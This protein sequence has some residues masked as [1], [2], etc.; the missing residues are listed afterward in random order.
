MRRVYHIGVGVDRQIRL[1]TLRL[2]TWLFEILGIWH[3]RH[4][5]RDV[6]LASLQENAIAELWR[7]TGLRFQR[8][9]RWF[10][11][12]WASSGHFDERTLPEILYS[13]QVE[14]AL[15]D[16]FKARHLA[17]KA[18]TELILAGRS[19]VAVPATRL[20]RSN[21][22]FYDAA[23]QPVSKRFAKELL[24]NSGETVIKPSVGGSS[25]RG[26]KVYQFVNG[27]DTKTGVTV[28]QAL[29][30]HTGDFMAQERVIQHAD[31]AA[32]HPHSLNTIRLV[33]YV[34]NGE[35]SHWPLVFRM[36]T[37][38]SNVDNAHA[39]GIYIGVQ[40]NGQ[41]LPFALDMAGRRYYTHPTTNLVF[42]DHLLPA[43]SAI[44][45]LGEQLLGCFPGLGIVS[46]DF[47]LR[48][49]GVP[50]L[51]EANLTG[52]SIWLSQMSHGAGAFGDRTSEILALVA[53]RRNA[54]DDAHADAA[55]F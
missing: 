22:I 37:G 26:V 33:T 50:V 40:D 35:V 3:R 43:V 14:P 5:Y 15:N 32:P 48:E 13:T 20:V 4:Q 31:Y 41:L 28:E 11:L 44:I 53:R 19:T 8:Y 55:T 34:V 46:W 54:R 25:G 7:P 9:R 10:R 42:E 24:D 45:H 18:L 36:G 52:Q 39:G 27:T 6:S 38:F 12:Y 23:R 47:S 2:R 1:R 51:I 30:S 17:D 29:R 16:V 49:D 21:G